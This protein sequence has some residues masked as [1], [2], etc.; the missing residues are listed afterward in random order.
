MWFNKECFAIY[1]AIVL[2]LQF[3]YL[4]YFLIVYYIEKEMEYTV[5]NYYFNLSRVDISIVKALQLPSFI[6]RSNLIDLQID[7]S[8][9][10]LGRYSD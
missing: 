2:G 10:G 7:V 4:S 6:S 1:I 8:T 9:L 5:K 3:L